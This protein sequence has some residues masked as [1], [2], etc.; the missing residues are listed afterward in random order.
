M[1]RPYLAAGLLVVAFREPACGEGE[2]RGGV[3][4]PCTRQKDCESPLVCAEGVCASAST[5]DAGAP[6]ARDSS[7]D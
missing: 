7:A 2:A 3:N 4:A 1:L 6:D 5:P